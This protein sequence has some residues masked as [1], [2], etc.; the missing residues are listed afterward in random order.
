MS[1]PSC[2]SGLHHRPGEYH[3][4]KKCR[5]H[6]RKPQQQSILRSLIDH[7]RA[8][9][10]HCRHQTYTDPDQ[11]L[12]H[13]TRSGISNT[14]S[15]SYAT[16]SRIYPMKFSGKYSCH[17]LKQAFII[18]HIQSILQMTVKQNSFSCTKCRFTGFDGKIPTS[19]NADITI[20]A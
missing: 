6:H 5:Q 17:S 1:D 15:A 2:S 14:F 9:Q 3:K 11:F 12:F 16:V 10:K 7:C 18:L 8:E 20:A 19:V 13:R 4:R